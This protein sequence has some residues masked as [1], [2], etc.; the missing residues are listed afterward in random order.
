MQIVKFNDVN[1][2]NQQGS[3]LSSSKWEA[4]NWVLVTRVTAEKKLLKY[5]LTHTIDSELSVM[6]LCLTQRVSDPQSNAYFSEKS[7][8][9]K[10]FTSPSHSLLP[11][12]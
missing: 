4:A 9:L 6:S 5:H 3:T 7:E 12:K 1:I 2:G 8:F 11:L 10:R